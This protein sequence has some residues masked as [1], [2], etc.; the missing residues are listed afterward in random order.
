M[1][2]TIQEG[3][4]HEREHGNNYDSYNHGDDIE[5]GAI[6]LFVG[7]VGQIQDVRHG[8]LYLGPVGLLRLPI[9]QL[10]SGDVSSGDKS[11][12]MGV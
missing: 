12:G 2:S 9:L 4:D 7:G 5:T 3:S 1:S 6:D 11:P 8:I 10:A